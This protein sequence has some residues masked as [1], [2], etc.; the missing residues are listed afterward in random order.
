M[1]GVIRAYNFNNHTKEKK[2]LLMKWKTD[3]DERL[4]PLWQL[5]YDKTN[6]LFDSYSETF[7]G[8]SLL[9]A[10]KSI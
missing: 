2:H 10:D 8:Y 4:E 3:E 5:L 6:V 7:S 1:E 9:N